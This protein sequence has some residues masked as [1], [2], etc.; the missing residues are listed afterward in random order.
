MDGEQPSLSNCCTPASTVKTVVEKC[1]CADLSSLS[2]LC[3]L[4]DF[5]T[6]LQLL[7]HL[8]AFIITWNSLHGSCWECLGAKLFCG[9]AVYMTVGQT[10]TFPFLF[11]RP[12]VLSR[13]RRNSIA[14]IC[15]ISQVWDPHQEHQ[16]QPRMISEAHYK[17]FEM[18]TL[19]KQ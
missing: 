9:N 1:S 11:L 10:C 18:Q 13:R 7:L 16:S 8:C 4:F 14:Q 5:P 12:I 19:A 2:K 15:T 3:I 6:I 17:C